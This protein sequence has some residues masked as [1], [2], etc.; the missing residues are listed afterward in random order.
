MKIRKVLIRLR[1]ERGLNQATVANELK[2][3]T[4]YY[5]MIEK[6]VRNPSLELAAKIAKY[7]NK[8]VEDIFFTC[9]N[10]NALNAPQDT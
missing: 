5:G 3:T 8:S 4:S 10:N 6:G 2:I 7:F 9:T 1:K